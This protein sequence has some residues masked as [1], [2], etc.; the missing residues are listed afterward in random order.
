M[1]K[2]MY[3]KMIIFQIKMGQLCFVE[4]TGQLVYQGE[5]QVEHGLVGEE[6]GSRT[7]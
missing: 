4:E 5:L 3:L 7:Y 2:L 1:L 6:E